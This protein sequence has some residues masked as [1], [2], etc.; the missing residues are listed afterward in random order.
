MTVRTERSA[1]RVAPERLQRIA[2]RLLDAST[3]C[4]LATVGPRGRAHVNTM[5]FARDGYDLIWI[6]APDSAHSR[7]IRANASAAVAVY[8]SRQRWGRPDRGVQVFGR[9]RELGG[10]AARDAG[11]VYARRFRADAEDLLARFRAYRLR[12][13]RLK[14]FDEREL[15][16]ATWV[17]ARVARDGGLVWSATEAHRE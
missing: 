17:V 13:S 1:R 9:A 6:S 10:R 16:D 2:R 11:A 8:D 3:L 4:A 5:Y 7:H 14:L 15:G 12:P